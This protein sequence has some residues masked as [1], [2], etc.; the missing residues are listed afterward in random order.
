MNVNNK[1]LVII[2]GPTAV[3]K[4]AFCVQL[5]KRLQTEIISADSRQFYKETV[6]GTAAPTKKEMDGVPHHFVGNLSIFDYYNVSIYEREAMA[7][8]GNLFQEKD[9][10]IATG[11]SGLYIDTL[12]YG[13]DNLPDIDLNLRNSLIQRFQ[14]EGLEPLVEQLQQ[15]DEEYFAIVDKKNPKRVVR[16]LEVCLQTGQTYTSLR[17]KTKNNRDFKIIKICLTL[18]RE[19]LNQRI[20]L[21]TDEMMQKGFLQ[22]A[23]KLFPYKKLNTLNTLGYRELFDYLEEKIS[24]EEAVDKIKTNTKRYAKRQMTWFKREGNNYTFLERPTLDD[25]LKI[26]K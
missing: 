9:F 17:K 5:A 11:G 19:Q 12:C 10:V 22:E 8:L 7:L 6:I 2:A 15:L 18:P 26:I 16:A 13:I 1:T 24:L 3:G 20:C 23:K 4:T 21:R 14:K 25:V